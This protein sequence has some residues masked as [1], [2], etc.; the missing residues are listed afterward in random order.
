MAQRAQLGPSFYFT[1]CLNV[2]KKER[3]S[4]NSRIELPNKKCF[5]QASDQWS[6]CFSPLPTPHPKT[7]PESLMTLKHSFLPWTVAGSARSPF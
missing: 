1:L 4:H 5:C 6:C 7:H 3:E 2:C